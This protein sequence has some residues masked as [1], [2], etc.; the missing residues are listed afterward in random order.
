MELKKMP[1][2][3][4]VLSSASLLTLFGFWMKM[5]GQAKEM[6]A[7]EALIEKRLSDLEK[8]MV[9]SNKDIDDI[10]NTLHKIDTRTQVILSKLE[11]KL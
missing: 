3:S 5:Q 11:N 10:K 9:E 4:I 6:G 7:K 8:D 2:T 1:E